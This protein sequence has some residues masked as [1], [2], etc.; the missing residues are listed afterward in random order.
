MSREWMIRQGDCLEIMR[1]MEESSID[2]IVTDP[3]YYQVKAV[4]WD[5]QWK[6]E[7]AFIEWFGQI[8]QEWRRLLRPNGSLYCFM[9]S[10]RVSQCEIEMGR[11]FNLLNRI[12]WVKKSTKNGNNGQWNKASKDDLRAFFPQAEYILFAEHFGADSAAKGESG[13]GQKCDELRG[14]VFEPLRAYLKGEWARAGL[15]PDDANTACGTAN[16]AGRH[17]F[18]RSQWCLPT[19]VHYAALREYANIHG[20]RPAPPYEEFHESPRYRFEANGQP[21]YLRADYD[22]LR[23]DYEDLRADYEDLRRPFQV[24]PQIPYTDVWTDFPTVAPRPGKH[25]CEKPVPM[26]EHIIAASSRPGAMVLDCFAG[27]G[28]TGEAALRLGRSFVGIERDEV[29]AERGRLRL[30]GCLLQSSLFQEAAG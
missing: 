12:V 4:A 29:W 13:Y 26:L 10:K 22:Y 17:F 21:D 27:S 28:S 15:T 3:P 18:T 23:A 7:D 1:G 24:A 8:C 14:F 5:L 20:R 2:L 9:G 16:M 6:S 11:S 30:Q 25:M 19:A